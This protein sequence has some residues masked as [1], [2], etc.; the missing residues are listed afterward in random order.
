MTRNQIKIIQI[1]ELKRAVNKI[2]EN[3]L[4]N[5]AKIIS[6]EMGRNKKKREETKKNWKIVEEMGR[7]RKK[8][9]EIGRNRNIRGGRT[10]KKQED[11]RKK[12]EETA[13]IWK[14]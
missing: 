11:T 1:S 5:K 6:L 8:Q 14:Q 7:N 9:E 12:Q 4:K 13:K 10:G 3:K 2:F